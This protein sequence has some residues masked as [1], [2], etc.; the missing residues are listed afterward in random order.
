MVQGME[1][2]LRR[3]YDRHGWTPVT[4]GCSAAR[5][6]RLDI[7]SRTE[8]FVKLVDLSTRPAG[9]DLPA[10]VD[11]LRWLAA[12]GLPAAEVVEHGSSEAGDWLVTR[13]VPGRSAAEPW[14]ADQRASVVDALADLAT[15]L[16]DLP[17]ANCP[18]DRTLSVT[19]PQA[20]ANAAA[21]LVD[22]ADLDPE[23][24]GWTVERLCRELAD[25]TPPT[26]D[27][28][29]CHGDLC[30]PNVLLDP[31]T[32]AVTGLID[33]GRLGRADRHTDLALTV[34]SL[35]DAEV[36]PQYGQ[37]LAD[38]FLVR[39]AGGTVDP[40]RIAFYQLLDEFF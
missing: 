14:P 17:P 24:L 19:V 38:R 31:V 40:E 34:R 11:R 8:Y 18:F 1:D 20:Y 4:V 3:R 35:A 23:R 15:T 5:V 21:G 28:V 16:H 26:E 36:N 37:R 22:L 30:L 27:L 33:V 25:T 10:E 29:V 7:G 9:D 13:A 32:C 6:F 2:L 12:Q 39:Y